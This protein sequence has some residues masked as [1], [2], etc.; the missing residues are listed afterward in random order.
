MDTTG[1]GAHG[2]CSEEHVRVDGKFLARGSERLRLK[3][4]TY[5]PFA[6]NDAGEAF[7]TQDDVSA[8]L[9]RMTAAGINAIRTYYVRPR[10]F[11]EDRQLQSD[12]RQAISD[13]VEV[14]RHHPSV[15]AHSIANEIPTDDWFTDGHQIED[16]C[17][18]ITYADREPKAA[19]YP[20]G[21]VCNSS[22]SE[23]LDKTPSAS[24]VVCSYNGGET[25]DECLRSLERLDCPDYEV[26]LVDDVVAEHI[27]VCNMAFR[28]EVLEGMDGFHPTYRTAGDDVDICW[29]VQ[30]SGHWIT[31]APSAF[32]WHHR[33]QTPAAYMKQQAGYGEAEALLRLRR[34][35]RFNTRGDG[36]W[37]GVVY[38][39]AS[40]HSDGGDVLSVTRCGLRRSLPGA[41]GSTPRRTRLPDD[42][43]GPLPRATG[44]PGVGPRRHAREHLSAAAGSLFPRCSEGANTVQRLGQD[45]LLV[46]RLARTDRTPAGSAGRVA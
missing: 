15:A 5:E 45:L 20:L 10:W 11:L 30:E 29:R 25:L 40:G 32:V 6:P 8:D 27:P 7:P 18:G 19:Y 36:Q 34:P 9:A 22:P 1:P 13:A 41:P 39:C 42:R 12:A 43:R 37:G 33:R 2:A 21:G 16:W 31:Y 24:V 44:R 3:G 28:R 26:V 35:D 14:G 17:V 38:G 4:V 23:M 46:G